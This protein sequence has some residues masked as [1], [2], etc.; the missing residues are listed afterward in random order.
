MSSLEPYAQFLLGAG[1]GAFYLPLTAASSRI[2]ACAAGYIGFLLG[3][4]VQ[5]VGTVAFG[6]QAPPLLDA[7]GVFAAAGIAA[8]LVIGLIILVSREK[9]VSHL[10]SIHF[11]S[12]YGI[13][14][15][16]LFH[17]TLVATVLCAVLLP[18]ALWQ[19]NGAFQLLKSYD[20]FGT[21]PTSAVKIVSS[22]ERQKYDVFYLGF[23]EGLAKQAYAK[24]FIQTFSNTDLVVRELL[25]ATIAGGI[26]FLYQ[27]PAGMFLVVWHFSS[28][29]AWTGRRGMP[30]VLYLAA[31]GPHATDFLQRFKKGC[32]GGRYRCVSLLRHA[33]YLNGSLVLDNSSLRVRG[34]TPPWQK[35]ENIPW[36]EAVRWLIHIAPV[37]A[38]DARVVSD[39]LLYEL[40]LIK[41]MGALEKTFVI[42]DDNGA[43]SVPEVTAQA[44]TVQKFIDFFNGITELGKHQEKYRFGDPAQFPG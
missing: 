38:I 15:Y 2:L 7:L 6:F 41:S 1:L 18:I 14:L 44:V 42:R 16:I 8:A 30:S 28:A 21:P 32:G 9:W 40:A 29:M 39:H 12:S 19:M 35:T 34:E 33:D 31:S 20:I 25:M 13:G 24:G 27:N 11:Y 37:I 3:A 43:E 23:G 22:I 17:F 36:Q 4:L 10:Q 26:A 5:C